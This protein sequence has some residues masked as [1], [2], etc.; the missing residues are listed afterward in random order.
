MRI[1]KAVFIMLMLALAAA[2]LAVTAQATDYEASTWAQLQAQI[3]AAADGDTITLTQDITAGPDVELLIV[4]GKS[5]TLD[6]NGHT[7]N[8][9]RSSMDPDG[10]VI[11]VYAGGDLTI[12]DSS[13]EKTGTITG[14][15]A[16]NGGGINNQGSLNVENCH[17]VR[18]KATNGGAIYNYGYLY[19]EN[20]SFKDN[21]ATT[22]GGAVYND[23]N[24]D[25]AISDADF[26]GNTATVSGGAI[27]NKGH[28]GFEDGTW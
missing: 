22:S 7:L 15:W 6:L 21:F 11:Q 13:D 3:N 5:I 20:C 26:D 14:G 9:N 18:N 16:N 23:T 25:I 10:H 24:G 17:F 2:L 1:R 4:S 12:M 28:I 27:Y 8:R 19:L